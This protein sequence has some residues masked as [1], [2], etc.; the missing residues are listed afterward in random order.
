M[1]QLARRMALTLSGAEKNMKL[2]IMGANP[3]VFRV[4][5][6]RRAAPNLHFRDLRGAEGSHTIWALNRSK[7]GGTGSS[8]GLGEK[9]GVSSGQ[10]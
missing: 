3:E 2:G 7:W 6:C 1:T 9:S 4:L 5:F 8:L 10:W